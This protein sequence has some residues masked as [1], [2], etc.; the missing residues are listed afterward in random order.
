MFS[1]TVKVIQQKKK[2]KPI[3]IPILFPSEP[4]GLRDST[5][6]QRG[7]SCRARWSAASGTPGQ[8]A[9]MSYT[10]VLAILEHGSHPMVFS[11]RAYTGYT[12]D[13]ACLRVPRSF[14]IDPTLSLKRVYPPSPV[15][16]RWG[17]GT[18][19]SP[20]SSHS[21]SDARWIR[22]QEQRGPQAN[23][24]CT[25]PVNNFYFIGGEMGMCTPYGCADELEYRNTVE[26]MP[27]SF[28]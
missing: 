19:P 22:H 6:W 21:R 13:S 1:V 25:L 5:A 3:R 11:A 9:A 23:T 24:S 8:R 2:S 27:R 14:S 12:R 4:K 17:Q 10:S 15:R 26:K 20:S 28:I 18:P 7:G 16:W